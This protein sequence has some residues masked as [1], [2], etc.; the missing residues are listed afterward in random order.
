MS[1]VKIVCQIWNTESYINSG[2]LSIKKFTRQPM[3]RLR[4]TKINFFF[5]QNGI[6]FLKGLKTSDFFSFGK[7]AFF[8]F[9]MYHPIFLFHVYHL[10]QTP[11]PYLVTRL[12]YHLLEHFGLQQLGDYHYTLGILRAF[13]QNF[14]FWFGSGMCNTSSWP[15]EN[16][17][18][19]YFYTVLSRNQ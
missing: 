1:V 7:R 3:V 12:H 11:S 6:M 8:C 13:S 15:A 16:I 19:R 9:L 14:C 17:K 5:A 10:V 4:D 2:C 18:D